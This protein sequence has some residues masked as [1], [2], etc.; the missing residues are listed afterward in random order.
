MTLTDLRNNESENTLN[1]QDATIQDQNSDHNDAHPTQS[2]NSLNIE[3][4]AN[5]S[6]S[7]D[8]QTS[9]TIEIDE[10]LE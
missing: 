6:F 2:Q 1:V 9:N 8:H 7:E 5:N 10:K 4:N 3:V